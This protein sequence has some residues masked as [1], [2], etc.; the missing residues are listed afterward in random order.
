MN[1]K[2]TAILLIAALMIIA[3]L[4]ACSHEREIANH[5]V[6]VKLGETVQ[7][8]LDNIPQGKT[9]ADYQW[10][11]GQSLSVSKSGLVQANE[12]GDSY[13]NA[14]LTYKGTEYFEYFKISVPMDLDEMSLDKNKTM[15]LVGQQEMLTAKTSVELP[16]G[17]Q[18]EWNSSDETV[19]TLERPENLMFNS[20]CNDYRLVAV[21]TG[22]AVVTASC[23]GV[24]VSCEVIVY[25]P[26]TPDE[27][28]AYL[29]DWQSLRYIDADGTACVEMNNAGISLPSEG[30]GSLIGTAPAGKYLVAWD[31]DYNHHVYSTVDKAAPNYDYTALLPPEYRPH[32][33]AEVEYIIR[34]TDGE[35]KQEAT[36]EHGVKG[37]RLTAVIVLENAATGEVIE[38]LYSAQGSSLPQSI[39][40]PEESIPEYHYGD[41]VENSVME[42]ALMRLLGDLWLENHSSVVFHEGAT[43]RHCSGSKVTLPDT[44]NKINLTVDRLPAEL[45]IPAS[46]SEILNTGLEFSEI[47]SI[48]VYEGSFAQ[49]WVSERE[50]GGVTVLPTLSDN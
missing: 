3:A 2:R 30:I 32:S 43:A 8:T 11:C 10:N 45:V 29:A 26:Q 9:A 37:M 31:Y 15:L 18:I 34:V 19:V 35:A 1:R 5:E 16:N 24:E 41:P 25:D 42:N 4:C 17:H 33:L 6:T 49:Q 14:T 46:V 21:G 22:R 20:H 12:M 48:T 27:I 38:T 44:I 36:Y 28:M 50:R 40:V 13:V 23:G 47:E 7:L 39:I